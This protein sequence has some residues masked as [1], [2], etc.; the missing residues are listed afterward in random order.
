VAPTILSSLGL[1][2][3]LLHSVAVEGTQALPGLGVAHH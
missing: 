2:P 1:E 3:E